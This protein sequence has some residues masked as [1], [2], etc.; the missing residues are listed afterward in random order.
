MSISGLKLYEKEYSG[1][2]KYANVLVFCKIFQVE[3]CNSTVNMRTFV[4]LLDWMTDSLRSLKQ[5]KLQEA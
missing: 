4:V 5:Q 1:A 2:K 3:P